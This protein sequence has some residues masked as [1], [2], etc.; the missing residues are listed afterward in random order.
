MNGRSYK[1]AFI[2]AAAV[3]VALAIALAIALFRPSAQPSMQSPQ[4]ATAQPPASGNAASQQP[5]AVQSSAP[6]PQL[7]AVQI[8]PE[9]LQRIG[10]K[11]GEVQFKRVND[12]IRASGNVE[13]NEQ[14]IA[15]VQTRFAG[16]IQQVFAN[17]TYQ[18]VRK[19]QPLFTIY[20]PEILSSEQE[21]VLAKQNRDALQGTSTGAASEADWLL[22]AAG[23]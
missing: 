6:E 13:I 20:S 7:N 1:V 3:A 9:R 4:P 21:Y 14:S 22:T 15:Y 23:Q 5:Q 12:E 18:Y 17:A 8:S 19:G 2:A 10:V 11:F 16:W